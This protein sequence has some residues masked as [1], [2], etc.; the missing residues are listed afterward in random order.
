LLEEM[1]REVVKQES[2]EDPGRRSRLWDPE[3][4]YDVLKYNKVIGRLNS[5]YLKMHVYI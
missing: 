4:V 1:G 5:F 3:E 2:P